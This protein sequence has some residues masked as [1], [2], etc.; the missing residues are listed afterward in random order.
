MEL[1]KSSSCLCGIPLG[2]PAPLTSPKHDTRCVCVGAWYHILGSALDPEWDFQGIS[3]VIT[4]CSW[5]SQVSRV[6]K[7]VIQDSVTNAIKAG[8]GVHR[9]PN[10]CE[11]SESPFTSVSRSGVKMTNELNIVCIIHDTVL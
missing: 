3:C 8:S 9:K 2:S 1:Y 6:I 11:H 7:K 4:C 5:R 10:D